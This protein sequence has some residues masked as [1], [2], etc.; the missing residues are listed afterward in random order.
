MSRHVSL[1]RAA[2]LVAAICL[3]PP[4]RAQV[5]ISGAWLRATVEGQTSTV[6][7]MKLKSDA[8]ARL[9]SVSTPLAARCTVHEMTMDGNLMRMRAVDALQIP[10]GGTVE[11]E[12]G[13]QHLMLEGL[14]RSL[15]EGETV[16]L[17]LQFVDARGNGQTVKVQA[18]VRALGA[19]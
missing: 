4:A 16:A 17:T 11:L 10:A 9:V 8:G 6:A 5:A 1:L 19:R 7:Y 18:A 2:A 12:E 15:K 14:K 13:H 3:A